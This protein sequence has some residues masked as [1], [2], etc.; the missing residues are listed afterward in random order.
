MRTKSATVDEPLHLV[1]AF[2]NRF[3]GDFRINPE[4][5]PLWKYFATLPLRSDT[6]RLNL[7]HPDWSAVLRDQDRQ[8]YFCIDPLYRTTGVDGP[9]IVN[10]SRAVMLLLGAALA[11]VIA[12][13]SWKLAG[14]IAAVAACAVFCLDPNF[15]AH[16]PLVKND[17]AITLITFSAAF[18]TYCLGKR[19]TTGS[20]IAFCIICAVAPAVK[21]SGL[22]VA[23]V[24]L[25]CLA[26]RA[27]SADPWQVGKRA[28]QSRPARLAFAASVGAMT[29]AFSI[30]LIWACYGLRFAPSPTDPS[31]RLNLANEV[32]LTGARVHYLR[33]GVPATSDQLGTLP[34]PLA[35]RCVAAIDR[36]RLMPHA[37]NYGFVYMHRHSLMRHTFLL[38]QYSETGWWYY[39]PLAMLFKTPTATLLAAVGAAAVLLPFSRRSNRRIINWPIICLALPPAIY[40]LMAMRTNLN[41]GLRHIFPVYPFVFVAIGVAVSIAWHD[42][43][44]WRR[45]VPCVLLLGLAAET[46]CAFPN[47]IPFFNTPSGGARGGLHLLC[48]SNLDWGQDLPLLADWQRRNPNEKLYLLYFGTAD[49][50]FYGVQYTNLPGG[51]LLGPPFQPVTAP[52]VIAISATHLQGTMHPQL[53]PDL[54]RL[55]NRPYREVLGGSIYLYDTPG[56]PTQP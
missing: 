27:L 36:H 3:V 19:I 34:L 56:N 50:A 35:V 55:R 40:M 54:E 24:M 47:Y 38:G 31:V 52:G 53:R 7:D 33:T 46:A 10:R 25:L 4:D 20:I 49:P 39:F 23:P 2:A 32:N 17:V 18:A 44:R 6:L 21:F 1:S 28:L 15:I 43:R 13:W 16:A 22:A 8:I 9:A 12:W 41:L 11:G 37:W 51:Y 5:P 26:M 42:L 48:D 30:L 29:V 14:P 45:F